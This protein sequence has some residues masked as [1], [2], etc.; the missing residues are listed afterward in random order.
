MLLLGGDDGETE[1]RI[2]N[3][4]EEM[5]SRESFNVSVTFVWPL[6]LLTFDIYSDTD[7]LVIIFVKSLCLYALGGLNV[8][9]IGPLMSLYLF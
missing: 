7:H 9:L 6:V 4:P 5:L 1:K 2:T 8:W 3:F